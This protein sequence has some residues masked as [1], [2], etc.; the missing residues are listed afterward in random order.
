MIKGTAPNNFD[1]VV[2]PDDVTRQPDLSV[3]AAADATQQF[4]VWN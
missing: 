4:V 1:R 2:C 3:T